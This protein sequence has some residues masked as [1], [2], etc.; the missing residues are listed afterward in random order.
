MTR[1]KSKE[2]TILVSELGKLPPQAIELEEAVL[3]A[4]LLEKEALE[5]VIRILTPECFYKEQNGKVYQAVL[6]LY[7][8]SEAIDILT[9]T[10]ELKRLGDL[11][12]VGGSYYVSTL[13]N[14]IASSANIEFHARIVVQKY[15]QRELIR[16]GTATIK[17]AYQDDIDVFDLYAHTIGQLEGSINNVIKYEAQSISDINANLIADNLQYC[18]TGAPSGIPSFYPKIDA[19]TNGWQKT[20]LIILAARP[21]MGK[22]AAAVCFAVKPA[23]TSGIPVAIFSLEMSKRQLGGR[24]QSILSGLNVSRIVK[25][26]LNR[27]EIIK[28]SRDCAP[29]SEAPIYID[30]TPA[31]SLLE[32]KSKARSLVSKQKVQLIVIDYLQ[33][34]RSGSDKDNREQE[35][36]TISRGLKALAKEL[37]IPIIALSQLSRAVESRKGEGCK[38]QLSDL[39]ES[40]AIEQD[41]DMVMFAYRPAYYGID[42]Y[43]IDGRELPSPGLFSLIFAKHR[44]GGLGEIILG[45]VDD[46][47][48][49]TSYDWDHQSP[50]QDDIASW[51]K[52]VTPENQ[53]QNFDNKTKNSTFVQKVE[54]SDNADG[55][56]GMTNNTGFLTQKPDNS[57][58]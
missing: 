57:H 17:D 48:K 12:F 53:A 32:L 23:I 50:D 56:K 45:F 46:N 43:E 10:Q 54:P 1:T 5:A 22:T 51:R 25:G 15:L 11:E 26:Q 16:T 44:N 39:R 42:L 31:L 13:T 7:K 29:L 34:M 24:I 41:A 40:G 8:K 37:D 20:D 55:I 49:V 18:E 19:F 6:N 36:S 3:G 33:L 35:I 14:R 21:G 4:L 58:F 47:A 9:V 27:E 2:K 28:M 52:I 30:D 38:P